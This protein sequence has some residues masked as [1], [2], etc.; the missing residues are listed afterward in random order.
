MKV[1]SIL[2]ISFSHIGDVVLSTAIIPPLQKRFPNAKISI[3]LGPK[4]WEILWGDTRLNEIII[5]DNH[6]IHAGLKG[7]IKLIKEIRARKFDLIIDLRDTIWS[8]FMGR[9]RWGMPI[10]K[11][12]DKSYNQLHAVDRYLNVLH[13]HGVD[14]VGGMPEIILLDYEK[15]EAIDFLI[16]HNVKSDDIVIGIHPGGS[17]KYKLWKLDRFINLGD[18]LSERYGAKILI[19]AGPDEKDLQDQVYE[20]MRYKP[21]L[22]QDVGLRKLAAIIQQCDLYIGN[23]TGPMHIASAVGTRVLSIF[24]STDPN[25]SGPYGNGNIV[26][27]AKIDCSPCHPGRNPGGCKLPS[28]LAIDSISLKQVSDV[29]GRILNERW[30]TSN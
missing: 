30:N 12:L 5:Y 7:K 17:W 13:N 8:H 11:K 14:E 29:V 24:G 19:F 16:S 22:V 20:K 4:A 18:I 27:S 28:C 23:D 21:I 6:G 9:K 3:M 1:E 2:I 26:I 15:Q 10:L 25:R